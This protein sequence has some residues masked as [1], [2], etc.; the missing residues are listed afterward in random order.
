MV[1]SH[2]CGNSVI[3]CFPKRH[4]H[5]NACT[6]MKVHTDGLHSIWPIHLGIKQCM[7]PCITLREFP[8]NVLKQNKRHGMQKELEP[9]WEKVSPGMTRGQRAWRVSRPD[10]NRVTE[11]SCWGR[12]GVRKERNLMTCEVWLRRQ[13]NLKRHIILLST[14][15]KRKAIRNSKKNKILY[16]E[17]IFHP[18]LY[19]SGLLF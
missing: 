12:G 19:F 6:M 17:V 16:N 9:I 15:R 4:R 8:E 2:L 14:R 13:T 11:G 7:S 5:Q 10:W 18:L 1:V 3:S